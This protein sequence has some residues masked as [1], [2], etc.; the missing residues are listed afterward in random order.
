LRSRP[1]A[2]G[3]AA[4]EQGAGDGGGGEA[5][6]EGLAALAAAQLVEQA[7]A[8]ASAEGAL[9]AG[10]QVAGLLGGLG[11][12]VPLAAL[13]PG[14]VAGDVGDDR[15]TLRAVLGA[16]GGRGVRRGGGHVRSSG[17]RSDAASGAD[18]RTERRWRQGWGAVAGRTPIWTDAFLRPL[19]RYFVPCGTTSICLAAEWTD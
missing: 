14:D 5:R 1:G 6:P 11:V 18:C 9:G 3:A 17:P 8:E 2:P 19:L 12:E 16:G 7:L 4:G 15:V 10:E 13:A